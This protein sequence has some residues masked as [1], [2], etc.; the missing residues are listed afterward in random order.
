MFNKKI[1][2]QARRIIITIV[3]MFPIFLLY[4]FSTVH[5][6]SLGTNIA[7]CAD[8][9]GNNAPYANVDNPDLPVL[10]YS[11]S[12]PNPF[13]LFHILIYRVSDGQLMHDTGGQ[14]ALPGCANAGN[15]T[16]D[17]PVPPGVLPVD[18]SQYRYLVQIRNTPQGDWTSFVDGYFYLYKDAK[19]GNYNG[20]N[21]CPGEISSSSPVKELC[22]NFQPSPVV[23]SGG[24]GVS[25]PYIWTC[26]SSGAGGNADSCQAGVSSGLPGLAGTELTRTICPPGTISNVPSAL[27]SQYDTNF[28]PSVSGPP[29]GPWS[30][31]C[32]NTCNDGTGIGTAYSRSMSPPVN[33]ACGSASG[34]NYCNRDTEPD[35]S[36]LCASGIYNNDKIEKYNEWIWSC[37]GQCGGA[38]A[39]WQAG[40]IRSCGWIETN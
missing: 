24:T 18:D 2:S 35:S 20:K 5:A 16:W 26:K 12:G 32:S 28:P 40:N 19:C 6:Q 27:C 9:P 7:I 29:G 10:F 34:Q 14:C 11:V 4:N 25:D 37:A 33:A 13:D 15:C 36:G 30:W 8:D 31:T 38:P 17:Y 39:N 23:V 1:N 22:N 21:F 3:I